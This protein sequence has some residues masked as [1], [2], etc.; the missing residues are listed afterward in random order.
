MIDKENPVEELKN[1]ILK[2]KKTVRELTS[3]FNHPRTSKDTEEK[4]IIS[5]QINS[6]K[7][8]LKETNEGVS[9]S[10]KNIYLTKPLVPKEQAVE[11]KETPAETVSQEI[12]PVTEPIKRK[13]LKV[14]LSGE[15]KTKGIEKETIKRLKKKE[16]EV[17]AEK[18][19]KPK[20]YA[21]TANKMFS[22]KSL[23]LLNKKAFQSLERD[24]IKGNLQFTPTTYI[25]LV[26]FTT[27]LSIF[28]ALLIFLFFL[29]FNFGA[30]LPIITR[31]TEEIGLRLL[32]VFWILIVIPLGTFITMYFYPSL[33]KKAIEYRIEQELP[34]AAINMAAI[35]G[36]MI[37]PSKIFTILISTEEYTALSKEFTK[38]LNEINVYGYNFVSALRNAA[39]N[40]PSK[41]LSELFSGL[42]TTIN[43]GGDL[44]S[45]FDERAKTLLFEHRLAKEKYTKSAE[46]FMD[47]Y[48]SVVI[49]APMILMLLL[50]MMKISGLGISFS[51][52]TITL[53]MVLGVSVI[54]IVFI[55]F[56]HMKKTD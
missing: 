26:L 4:K 16:E 10:L 50:M 18:Q 8:S 39:F 38:V 27:F 11:K 41:K 34:F 23:S 17:I 30:E 35:S 5:S 20:W 32:K 14:K 54:N 46:T 29:F 47:I 53:I 37:D 19:K 9:Q 31:A 52:S 48:I 24:L 22:K 36:S 15:L 12:K 42:A 40:S 2:V 49:A 51:T 44:P 25:S 33:E 55:T 21:K 56:L 7:N 1:N 43:S 3:L 13:K 45:F 28:A 6:L